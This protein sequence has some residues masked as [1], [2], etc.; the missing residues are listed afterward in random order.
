[1]KQK[2]P[3]LA[4]DG[5]ILYGCKLI[6]IRRKNP[7]FKGMLALPGGFVEYGEKTEK[8]AIREVLEETGLLTVIDSLAGIYSDPRRDPRGHTVSVVY[9]LKVIGGK[10]LA[11]DDAE[12]IELILLR[13][14]HRMKLAFDHK[15]IL[16]EAG[17]I[18]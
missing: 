6:L 8:A 17:F 5:I 11:G 15:Q 13:D 16:K 7:P 4:V 2:G 10:L 18:K 1:M 14:I 12:K 3:S 9:R